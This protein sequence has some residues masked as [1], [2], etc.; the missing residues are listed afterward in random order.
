MRMCINLSQV[1]KRV[2]WPTMMMIFV[3]MWVSLYSVAIGYSIG[4]QLSVT[5]AIWSCI[6][7]YGVAGIFA[8]F[9]GVI[10]VRKGLCS[11]VLAKGPLSWYGQSIIALI[12][13][14]IYW[15]WVSW[16]AG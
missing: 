15:I 6:I 10:G 9:V 4:Q 7:G 3:G 8:A 16:I 1:G 13:F 14:I 12:M 5:P 11:Y 2:S